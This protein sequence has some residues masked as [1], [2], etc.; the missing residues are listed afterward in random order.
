MNAKQLSSAAFDAIKKSDLD[1]NPQ[2]E[3]A[4]I[5]VPIPK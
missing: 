1:L 2:M 3:G 4:S 5:V